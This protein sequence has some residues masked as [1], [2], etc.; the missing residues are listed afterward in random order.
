MLSR[1]TLI[2][3]SLIDRQTQYFLAGSAREESDSEFEVK[4]DGKWFGCG[5]VGTSG[6]LCEVFHH[7]MANTFV[8]R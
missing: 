8:L 6:G 5:T 2:A 3:I 1:T 4:S 7:C